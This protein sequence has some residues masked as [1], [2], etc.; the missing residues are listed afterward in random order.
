MKFGS[1][2][3]RAGAV[4]YLNWGPGSE[5]AA[6]QRS[7]GIGA[8]V[9]VPARHQRLQ[10]VRLLE[11]FLLERHVGVDRAGR[12]LLGIVGLLLVLFLGIAFAVRGGLAIVLDRDSSSSRGGRLSM[13]AV[14]LPTDIFD[15]VALG[16]ARA[17]ALQVVVGFSRHDVGDSSSR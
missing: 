16:S 14:V 2:G 5:W 1:E 9:Q 11:G 7:H 4:V 3:Q 6:A 10:I 13:A 8:A 15:P 12:I 17:A